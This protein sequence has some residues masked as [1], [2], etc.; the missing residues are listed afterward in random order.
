MN[1][2]MYDK[3]TEMT[4]T[5]RYSILKMVVTAQN[6]SPPTIAFIV[7]FPEVIMVISNK[8]DGEAGREC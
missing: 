1:A 6:L 7:Y 5:V 8:K 4:S 2:C 3:H